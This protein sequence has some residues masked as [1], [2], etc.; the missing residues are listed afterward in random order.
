MQIIGIEESVYKKLLNQVEY[1]IMM[2]EQ[3]SQKSQD[4]SLSE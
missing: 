2:V 1:L 3:L 4:N